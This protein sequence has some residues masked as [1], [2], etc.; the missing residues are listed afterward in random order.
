M[1]VRPPAAVL[2]LGL[3]CAGLTGL[4]ALEVVD[5]G[6]GPRRPIEPARAASGGTAAARGRVLPDSQAQQHVAVILDRPLFNPDRRPDP[7]ASGGND[8]GLARL[9]GIMVS[10]SGSVAIFAGRPGGK[11]VVVEQGGRIGAFVVGSIAD[12]A[13]TVTGPDGRRVLRPTFD[14]RPP[15]PAAAAPIARPA[16]AK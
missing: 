14:P 10:P 6:G 16:P 5:A 11:P 12:G 13:V 8:T 4:V 7:S 9:T 2:A 1:T 15:E 3:L